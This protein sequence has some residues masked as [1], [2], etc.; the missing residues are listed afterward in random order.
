MNK[1]LGIYLNDHLAGSLPAWSS[2]SAPRARTRAP[3]TVRFLRKLAKE[4][5]EDREALQA[6]MKRLEVGE[7]IPKKVGAW[8]A[9]KLG[10][11]K[12]NGQLSGYSPLSRVVELE[13]LA[14]GITG[15]LVLWKALRDLAD[16]EP[17]LDAA[18]LDRLR[19]RAERQQ[20]DMEEHRMRAAREAFRRRRRGTRPRPGRYAPAPDELGARARRAP[21]SRG[22]GPPDGR[23]RAGGAPARLAGG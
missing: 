23:P 6:I 19:E 15:N 20:H 13:G 14:L 11:L 21:P 16:E 12:P 9:E 1:L 10:R 5:Q 7:D 2:R 17:R 18:E 4:I 3:P 8:T 22:A